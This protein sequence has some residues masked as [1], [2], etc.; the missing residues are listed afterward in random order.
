MRR[1][2]AT[3]LRF[4]KRQPVTTALRFNEV[5]PPGV[6]IYSTATI[7]ASLAVAIAPNL[8]TR[9]GFLATIDAAVDVGIA[10][11]LAAYYDNSVNRAPHEWA[12]G[13][14]EEAAALDVDTTAAHGVAPKREAS[15][16]AGFLP[17]D[18]RQ[19]DVA[20]A[21]AWMSRAQR[22]SLAV[23][24]REALP[25]ENF[26]ADGWQ[27][28][29]R[30]NRPDLRA[31][32][33]DGR[34]LGEDAGDQWIQLLRH[35]R[36]APA[37][38]WAEARRF[39]LALTAAFGAGRPIRHL[40]RLPWQE[41]RRPPHGV[42]E[43]GTVTPPGHVPCYHPVPGAPVSLR[44]WEL[45]STVDLDLRFRCPGADGGDTGETVVIPILRAY[46]VHNDVILRRTSNNLILKALSLSLSI[47]ADSWTWGWQASLP[48]SHLDDVL[49]AAGDA[50]VEF[51]AVINGVHWLLLG[52]KVK[53][54][55]R[56]GSGRIAL[57]GRGIAAELGAP[58]APS[59]S[60]D[61]AGDDLNAQ[62]LM[63]AA[64]QINGVGIG[65]DINWGLVDWLVPAGVW[66][67]T[68]SHIEAV[69]R[70]A[71]AG[72]G[73]VQASRAA[74]TLNILPRYPVLPWD[75]ATSVM[76]D[77]SLPA[78]ATTTE[79]IEWADNPDYNAVWVSG[80]SSGILAQVLRQGTAGDLAA[81]MIVDPLNTHA[82]AARQ[83]GSA[84]L[85]AS[86]RILRQTLETPVLPGVGLYPV[87]SFVEFVDG[88]TTRLGMVR[89]VS[90]NANLP[91]VRQT[92]EVECHG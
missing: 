69:A 64:L 37:I 6:D 52:E 57:S 49:H 41:A 75:W 30:S 7:D 39:S 29:D 84:V 23:P 68:G 73:Y 27:V 42:S 13:A 82:D 62:Q 77:F 58:Y 46:I 47:D 8:A 50:P 87:G 90:V 74:K 91:R 21:W 72:G 44:F 48:D 67:H 81:P 1:L 38:P 3:D 2:P 61:N 55:R 89:A 9:V 86:G 36:P 18:R 45:M 24:W 78:A 83:R 11:N 4:F 66:N 20:A 17:G 85:G 10:P 79:A 34:H 80:E 26:V 59:V 71:E 35:R 51:E 16:V 40:I 28:L 14:W 22:P 15:V 53:R 31:G 60:R 25:L 70:I 43:H 65:W 33:Q 88:A 76:P 54:D 32:W 5:P 63:A 92:I 56:F 12:R 19:A